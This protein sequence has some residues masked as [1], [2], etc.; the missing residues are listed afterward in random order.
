MSIESPSV[1][2][3]HNLSNGEVSNL[4]PAG[5]ASA[6]GGDTSVNSNRPASV[7]D[8]RIA[9]RGGSPKEE[10]LVERSNSP[11]SDN[12][13]SLSLSVPISSGLMLQQSRVVTPRSM[14][15]ER[16]IGA[17]KGE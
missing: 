7:V 10:P 3:R 15:S 12:T 6:T 17:R 5:Y 16:V 1:A 4:R 8:H 9:C 13:V 11:S 14:S 2:D